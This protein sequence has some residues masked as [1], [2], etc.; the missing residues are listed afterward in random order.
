MRADDGLGA[1]DKEKFRETIRLIR[2]H[3]DCD[4]IINCT[5]S[6]ASAEHPATDEERMAHHQ[7]LEGIEMGSYDAG[8]FNWMPGGVFMN[9]RSFSRSW[10]ICI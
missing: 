8:T 10:A 4:V 3:K 6:G 5:S 9:T 1:M 7:E 2:S